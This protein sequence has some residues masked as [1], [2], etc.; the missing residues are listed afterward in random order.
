[1]SFNQ[2]SPFN[3]RSRPNQVSNFPFQQKK[4]NSWMSNNISDSQ[5][6]EKVFG[7]TKRINSCPVCHRKELY[8]TGGWRRAYYI[9]PSR[10]GS[11]VLSNLTPCCTICFPKVSSQGIYDYQLSQRILTN[12]QYNNLRQQKLREISSSRSIYGATSSIYKSTSNL[13]SSSS[14]YKGLPKGPTISSGCVYHLGNNRY[15]NLTTMSQ[16]QYCSTH[17][18]TNIMPMEIDIDQYG[19]AIQSFNRNMPSFKTF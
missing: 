1:M 15:C 3:Y 16:S 19:R 13:K 7:T 9:S 2:R 10:G 8:K 12:Y 14:F 6:W 11:N 4:N 17:A 18:N 5:V